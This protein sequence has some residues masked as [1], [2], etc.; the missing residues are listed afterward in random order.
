LLY[1]AHLGTYNQTIQSI[2]GLSNAFIGFSSEFLDPLVCPFSVFKA[3]LNFISNQDCTKDFLTGADLG[4]SQ[5][6]LGDPNVANNNGSYCCPIDPTLGNI[7][8]ECAKVAFACILGK[9]SLRL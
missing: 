8:L 4:F 9:N 7:K 5:N 1:F 6:P 2:S 3:C